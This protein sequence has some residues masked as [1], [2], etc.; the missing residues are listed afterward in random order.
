MAVWACLVSVMTSGSGPSSR[1]LP[2]NTMSTCLWTQEA[3]TPSRIN[4]DSTARVRLPGNRALS[5]KIFDG[6]HRACEAAGVPDAV[7][8]A[9]VML[10]AMGHGA[11]G[12]QAVSQGCAEET[13]F[14][15]VRG[16]GVSAKQDVDE[17]GLD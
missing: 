3:M 1:I 16:Q 14:H 8:G 13:G 9:K 11:P 5:G 15:V 4:P 7:D 17:A 2:A 10:M 6:F 12:A